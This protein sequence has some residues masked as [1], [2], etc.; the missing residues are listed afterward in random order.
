M[1]RARTVAGAAAIAVAMAAIVILG[2][3]DVRNALLSRLPPQWAIQVKA[4]RHDVAV[5]HDVRIRMADG[6][7][8]AGSLYRPLTPGTRKLPTVLI[9]LPYGRLRYAEAYESAIYFAQHDY[10]VLV[11]D[12]RGT[13]DSGGELL[14]WRDAAGDGMSILDWIAAQSWSNGKVGTFGCSALGETQLALAAR[15]HPAHAAIIASGAG[16]GVGSAAGQFGF[17]GVFEGGVF[18][19][20]S[21]FGW[22]VRYGAKSSDAPPP[23]A[24]DTREILRQLPVSGLVDRVRPSPNGYSDFLATPLGDP[25]WHE[26]GYVSDADRSRVPAFFVNT[27][28]DQTVGETL[29]LARTWQQADADQ[30]VVIAPGNHC[31]QTVFDATNASWGAVKVGNAAVPLDEWYLAWFDRWLRNEGDGLSG[32][33]PYTYYMLND[34]RW[35]EADRWPPADAVKRR[36]WLGSGGHANSRAGDGTLSD[37]PGGPGIVDEYRYDPDDPVP[38]RGG[39]TCCTGDPAIAPGPAD[40]ADVEAR[41]DVLVYTSEPLVEDLRI[42]GPLRATLSFASDAPDTDLVA[43]LVDVRPDGTAINIQEGALRLRYRDGYASPALLEPGRIYRVTVE[44]RDIAYRVPAGH[45]LRLQVTSSSFP[46]LE[47]N[48]NTGAPSN[49]AETLVRIANN[50]VYHSLEA[51][52]YLELFVL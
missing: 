17:F 30:R 34:D 11:V 48:L 18:E 25:R 42:A 19:L 9:R 43:R 7:D 31:E 32:R 29:A 20:A 38:S 4:I 16:G 36:W 47:R 10:A 22:F 44:M 13:G 39:P 46:R 45:R 6:I 51:P 24:F 40:Q 14:P 21:G 52:S 33:A 8:L 12:L 27:W 41:K 50:R 35:Y 15:N 3:R 37:A 49:A 2:S 23:R 1:T 5:D 28:G 26:W